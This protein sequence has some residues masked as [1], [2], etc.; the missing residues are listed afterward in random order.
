MLH[1][2]SF[3]QMTTWLCI[4]VTTSDHLLPIS[5]ADIEWYIY[6][7]IDAWVALCCRMLHWLFE[8]IESHCHSHVRSLSWHPAKHSTSIFFAECQAH[9]STT[10]DVLSWACLAAGALSEC[11][12]E[13]SQE[14]CR[15]ASWAPFVEC[16]CVILYQCCVFYREVG[17]DDQAAGK[18]LVVGSRQYNYWGFQWI[19]GL[20]RFLNIFRAFTMCDK[21]RCKHTVE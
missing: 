5:Y 19:Q 4:H 11:E 6:I 10:P 9:V 1:D 14:Q 16:T 7:Y 15:N 12:Y 21:C 18:N 3:E 20:F 13:E 8:P 2:V 17:T